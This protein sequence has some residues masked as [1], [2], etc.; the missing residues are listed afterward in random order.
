MLPERRGY[1]V[2]LAGWEVANTGNAFYQVIDLN[3]TDSTIPLPPHAVPEALRVKGVT[4]D[5]ISLAWSAP[6][7]AAAYYNIYRDG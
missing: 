2:L 1:H 3:F 5:T 6:S 4:C 7:V